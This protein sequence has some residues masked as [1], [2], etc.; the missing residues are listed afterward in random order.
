[1]LKIIFSRLYR[2]KVTVEKMIIIFC[3]F[4]HGMKSSLCNDCLNLLN[5]SK[6]RIDN[7]PYKSKKP[8]CNICSIHCYRKDMR[9]KIR[10]VMR[11]SG[12]RML[13]RHPILA[14]LHIFDKLRREPTLKK[15]GIAKKGSMHEHTF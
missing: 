12:P 3:S 5:Y 2:E 13:F 4:K 7:C 1:M 14:L 11:Y 15:L 9:S 10:E 6:L 8:V